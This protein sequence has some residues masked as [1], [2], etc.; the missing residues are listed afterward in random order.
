MKPIKTPCKILVRATNWVGDAIMMTP[1]LRAVRKAFPKTQIT[2]LA[3]PWVLPVFQHSADLDQIMIY[4]A[5]SRH[6]GLTGVLR[7]AADLRRER[8]DTAILFQNA[9]EAALLAWLAAIPTRIGFS[10]DAR[11]LLLSHPVDGWR[12][13]K[14]G[15]FVD[16]CLGVLTGVGL[17]IDGRGLSLTILAEERVQALERLGRSSNLAG[18]RLIGLNPGAAYGTAKRWPVERYIRLGKH[19]ADAFDASILIFGAGNEAEVGQTLAAGIGPAARN[20]AGR[21]SLREA[22]ALI[23][24]CALFVT[25]DS[26]LMHV[27]A[28]LNTPQVAIIGPTDA[29]ATGPVNRDSVTVQAPGSCPRSPC[30]LPHC[31]LDHRCMTAVTEAEVFQAAGQLLQRR[32]QA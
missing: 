23:S 25:N 5:D 10:T 8:F 26:G 17:P 16:Y 6:K 13:L 1:A 32:G 30:L 22:M 7:L 24:L 15:H 20:L 29:V 2:L 18:R 11:R 19:L 12:K 21:T 14:K 28:A 9:F 31:P 27:A 3:K 4:Q